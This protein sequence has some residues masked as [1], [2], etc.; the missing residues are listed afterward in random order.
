MLVLVDSISRLEAYYCTFVIDYVLQLYGYV[1]CK[2]GKGKIFVQVNAMLTN[3]RTCHVSVFASNIVVTEVSTPFE[4]LY[5]FHS[6]WKMNDES[7]RPPP[8]V[9]ISRKV[10]WI[11]LFSFCA[12]QSRSSLFRCHCCSLWFNVRIARSLVIFNALSVDAAGLLNSSTAQC[13][14]GGRA[15]FIVLFC[16]WVAT[17]DGL[18][19]S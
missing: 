12:W 3:S 15:V 9:G 17:H 6:L 5:S 1:S 4:A 11:F 19:L 8:T 10:S 14:V 16:H 7:L 18:L 2:K 13:R